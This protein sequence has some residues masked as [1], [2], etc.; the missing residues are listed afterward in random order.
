MEDLTRAKEL[1][2][3]I[4]AM[5][6]ALV[7]TGE[8]DNEIAEVDAY[9]DLM[10]DREPLI[11]E[12]T[13]IKQILNEEDLSSAEYAEIKKTITQITDLDQ[14][15]M[16]T[17]EHMYKVAKASFKDVKQGQRI[18]KG[19]HPLPGDEVSSKFDMKQ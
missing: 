12:L 6:R 11:S 19:Y 16:N 7:L 3:Q 5:T 8:K 18:H 14:A 13:D 17:I 10:E 2:D 9:S 4:L 1:A 15:Q